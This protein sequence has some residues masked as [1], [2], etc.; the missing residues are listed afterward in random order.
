MSQ[1][2]ILTDS[3][4]LLSSSFPG[5]E[6]IS[7]I[8]LRVKVDQAIFPDSQDSKQ[9]SQLFKT[10]GQL[11]V[12]LPPT[13]EDFCQTFRALSL[14]YSVILTIL[15]SVQLNPAVEIAQEAANRI[16]GASTIYIIDSQT[17]AAGLGFLVQ[18]AA[19]AAQQGKDA[20]RI[21]S[22]VRGLISHVYTVFCL[23]S[24]SYLANSDQI[25]PAQAIVGEMLGVIPFYIMEGGRLIPIQKAR[26]PRHLVDMLHE[27]VAEFDNLKQ[28]AIVQGFPPYE[29]E[30]RNLRDR[31]LQDISPNALSEYHLSQ[32]T[33]SL[34]GPHSLGVFALEEWDQEG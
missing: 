2:G 20:N 32:A 17:T 11:P 13:V 12:A 15:L 6:H 4:A 31:L 25:D 33:L 22:L 30:A 10:N 7:I 26:S 24:L 3:T 14:K 28:V 34:L 5:H 1:I 16:K 29:Q 27:F 18:A 9:T 21:N 8:P 23:Q 19:E